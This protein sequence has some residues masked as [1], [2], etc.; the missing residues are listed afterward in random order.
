MS[1]DDQFNGSLALAIV[2]GGDEDLGEVMAGA[3]GGAVDGLDLEEV[4]A[5]ADVAERGDV[6]A[7]GGLLAGDF[8]V[9]HQGEVIF[10]EIGDGP[11]AAADEHE[12]VGGMGVPIGGG[13]GGGLGG[14]GQ[15]CGTAC[16]CF[17]DRFG[18]GCG[19]WGC[20][21]RIG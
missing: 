2:G 20:G 9:L 18:R 7:E 4:G 19:G 14:D 15:G 11:A 13:T 10:S 5:G 6:V 16:T 12:D 3:P 1:A 21:L 17:H 8:E